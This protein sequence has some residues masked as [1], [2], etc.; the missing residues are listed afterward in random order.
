MTSYDGDWVQLR[1]GLMQVCE[2][3]CGRT[4]GR[5][6]VERETW[7]WNDTVQEAIRQKKRTYK[8]WQETKREV[9]R[10]IFRQK[11][12]A[13]R[14]A[15]PTAKSNS[16]ELWSQDLRSSSGQ[17]KMFKM[18]KRMRKDQVDVGGTNYIND[19]TGNVD[20]GD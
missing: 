5:H 3:V 8:K 19:E 20:C 7:W 1:G 12:N 2:D 14:R 6:G 9:D 4:T 18:T 13:A 16:W 15:V 11:S 17:R 10:M